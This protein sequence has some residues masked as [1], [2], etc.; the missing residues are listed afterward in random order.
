MLKI[1]QH[2]DRQVISGDCD[3][4]QGIDD[5][6][7]ARRYTQARSL[8][9]SGVCTSVRP[10]LTFVYCIQTA[11]H[12]VQAGSPIILV[13]DS[14]RR[15]PTLRGTPSVGRNIHGVGKSCDFR[16]KSPPY[17]GNGTRQDHMVAMER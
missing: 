5:V 16:L 2:R 10:S 7:T 6:F 17:L 8:L 12:I 4:G 15:H 9:S 3:R 1:H 14:E 13:L 11:E